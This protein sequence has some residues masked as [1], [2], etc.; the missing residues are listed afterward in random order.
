MDLD[1]MLGGCDEADR[2]VTCVL[3][4]SLWCESSITL[5]TNTRYA[6][7]FDEGGAGDGSLY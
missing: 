6:P 7:R 3:L 4:C 5:D 1:S 2:E